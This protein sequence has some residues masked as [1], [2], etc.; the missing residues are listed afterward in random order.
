MPPPS[1]NNSESTNHESGVVFV[2]VGSDFLP[3]IVHKDVDGLSVFAE[4]DF[5]PKGVGLCQGLRTC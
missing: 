1:K 5:A 3:E 4:A 2:S